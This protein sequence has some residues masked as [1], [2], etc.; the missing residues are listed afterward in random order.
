MIR[1][2]FELVFNCSGSLD[3]DDEMYPAWA[4]IVQTCLLSA[5]LNYQ[6]TKTGLTYLSSKFKGGNEI[7]KL[8]FDF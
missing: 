8:G 3:Y 5:Q 7:R 1:R 4:A 2:S 6:T